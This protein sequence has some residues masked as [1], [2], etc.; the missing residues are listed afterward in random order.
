MKGLF[1][2]GVSRM[3]GNGVLEQ[4]TAPSAAV[5]GWGE[6]EEKGVNCLLGGC[7]EYQHRFAYQRSF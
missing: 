4:Y 7:V 3:E 1:R 2:D 5:A 6:K